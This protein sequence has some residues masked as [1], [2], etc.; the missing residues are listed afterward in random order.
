MKAVPFAPEQKQ[1]LPPLTG[2][3]LN[4][5]SIFEKLA[6]NKGLK[7][8]I[9]LGAEKGEQSPLLNPLAPLKAGKINFSA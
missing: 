4:P 6:P 3:V 8:I 2:G 9:N 1:P 5:G 7:D